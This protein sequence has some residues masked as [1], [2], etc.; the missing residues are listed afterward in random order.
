[1]HVVFSR[2]C[3]GECVCMCSECCLRIEQGDV[4]MPGACS[5]AACW[6]PSVK[7]VVTLVLAHFA[8]SDS[9]KSVAFFAACSCSVCTWTISYEQATETV[10][11]G[12]RLSKGA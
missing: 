12:R 2:C 5:S 11:I 4:L 8:V 6:D 7:T 9:L 1:M 3:N 10:F